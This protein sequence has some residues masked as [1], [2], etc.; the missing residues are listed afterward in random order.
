MFG[1]RNS[2][3]EFPEAIDLVASNRINV[4][5]VLTETI[6]FDQLADA[7]VKLSEQPQNYLKIASVL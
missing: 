1:S 3:N 5:S 7:V 6:P 4:T 2:A